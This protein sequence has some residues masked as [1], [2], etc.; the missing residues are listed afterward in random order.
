MTEY[1]RLWESE[2]RAGRDLPRICVVTGEDAVAWESCC[3]EYHPGDEDTPQVRLTGALPVC[4][5]VRRRSLLEEWIAAIAGG[6]SLVTVVVGLIVGARFGQIWGL[7]LF[8]GGC[9]GAVA[10]PVAAAL[11]VRAVS[12]LPKIP[13]ATVC[14]DRHGERYVLVGPVHPAFAAAITRLPRPRP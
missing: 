14:G 3:Y 8:L 9:G 10:V 1:V 4:A 12:H 7:W 6:G 13:T 2:L 5:R 11:G